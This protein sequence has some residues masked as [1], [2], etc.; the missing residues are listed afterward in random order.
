MIG[1][2]RDQGHRQRRNPCIGTVV[3]MFDF[4]A[5]FIF[6]NKKKPQSNWAFSNTKMQSR[7]RTVLCC[8]LASRVIVWVLGCLAYH[9]VGTYDQSMDTQPLPTL[10]LDRPVASLISMF[11]HWD[12]IHF[13]AI[14]Q[15]GYVYEK[16]FAFF[17]FI[18]LLMRGGA[19]L[20]CTALPNLI[21]PYYAMILCGF[22]ASNVAF[23]LAAVILYQY[24]STRR[25]HSC[26]FFR[27][28][29][30]RGFVIFVSGA[31]IFSG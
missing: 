22:L 25:L 31:F 19:Y 26:L 10:P 28:I 17:P 4:G 30:P 12:S 14:A 23:I 24:D 27:V 3:Y 2:P 6:F 21:S 18:P 13:I 15:H 29:F 11:A 9:V 1:Q 20:L 8:A 16:Q 7:V 5:I